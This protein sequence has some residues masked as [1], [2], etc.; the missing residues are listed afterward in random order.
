M[1][2]WVQGFQTALSGDNPLFLLL[3]TLIGLVVGV[4]PAIGPSFGV[5][6]ALPFTYAMGPAAALILLTAIQSACAFGDSIASILINVPGGPGTVASMWE[7]Y[8]LTRRGRGGTALG[9]A[10]GGSVIGGIIGWLSFVL[11]AGP[12]TAFALMIGA[13]E[14][15]V[16]GIMALALISI[17]SKG[18]T[19]KG[20]LM[21]CLGLLMG[22]VGP[23]PISALT[24]RFSF[25]LSQLEPGIEITLGALAIF[26]LPQLIGMLQEGGSIAGMSPIKDSVLTGVWEV[27][28]RPWTVLRGGMIGWLIGVLP[29]L[30][31]SAAGITAYLVEKKFS[32]ESA[33]FGN[34]SMDGLTAAETGKGA[35]ILGDGITSLMLGVPGSVTWAI[36]MAALMIHGVQPGPRFMTSGVLPYTVFAGLLLGQ[37]AYFVIGIFTVRY[38]ARI[39]YV[40]NQLLAPIIAI[41]CFMGAFVAKNYTYD[42]W[43]MVGLGIFAFFATRN[44]YPT[45]PM[46]LGFILADLIESNFH[47]SLAI[48]YDSPLI[49][50]QR[51]ISLGLVIITALF[52]A[53]P[54]ILDFI[55]SRRA[56]AGK[57]TTALDTITESAEAGEVTVG[58]IAFGVCVSLILFVLMFTASAY[59]PQIRMFPMLVSG[60]GLAL[61]AYYFLIGLRGKKRLPFT[62]TG[63]SREKGG[64]PWLLGV[65]SVALY[66]LLVPVL[67]FVVASAAYFLG[68]VAVTGYAS[69]I[70]RWVVAIATTVGVLIFLNIF[71]QMLNVALPTGIFGI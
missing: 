62:F 40:P 61:L 22:M 16:L 56:A 10:A 30:G 70:R 39:A 54:W 52:I 57:D 55:R 18:E 28:K 8:P 27:L 1:D 20:L 42:I 36:L 9:I 68:V 2:M 45:V 37:I 69:S 7:G 29:A 14:Y 66:A 65:G 24:F 58:E 43:I 13:P 12:M 53:W 67:G 71:T 5:T 21:G 48:G 31:T 23:D 59:R 51:P 17:A 6:L 47:R 60:L 19:I 50:L 44:G 34:G 49:F 32:K 41:L 35:C 4:L 63:M 25:G 26:A 11:L 38:I 15:F 3:G 33:Q 64:M 46:I